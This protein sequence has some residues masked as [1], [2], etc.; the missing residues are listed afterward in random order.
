MAKNQVDVI[1]NRASLGNQVAHVTR[2]KYF[3]TKNVPESSNITT[4]D[5]NIIL[6]AYSTQKVG[7]GG[8]FESEIKFTADGKYTLAR[9]HGKFN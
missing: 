2:Y 7:S 9:P 3:F 1:H 4:T 6:K 5:K 8:I